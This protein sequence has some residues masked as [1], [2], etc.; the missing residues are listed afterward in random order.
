MRQLTASMQAKLDARAT[1]FCH[2]WRLA[3]RD[4]AIM[5]FTDHDRDLV[6][7]GV[8]FRANT[9]LSASQ[10]E[11]TLGLGVGGAEAAGAL[12]YDGLR[13]SDLLNGLY[14][15]ASVEI[16]LVDWSQVE[17][18][19]LLDVATI[20]EIRRGEHVF[21]A[22]LRSSAH[23]FDQQQGRAFQRGCAADLGDARCGVDLGAAA[24]HTAGAVVSFEGGVLTLDL[25]ASFETGFFAGG[26]LTFTSGA[27]A[28][29][30]LTI[31]T[32]V[33]DGLRATIGLWRAPGA[34]VSAGDAASLTAGCDKSPSTCQRKFDNIVNFRGFPHMPGNDR[35][36]AYPNSLAKAMDGGSFFR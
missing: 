17:D 6:F 33:Q 23:V 21:S 7:N 4:G 31:K 3:R 16:W 28:G 5:G 14:D 35:V 10:I 32:H 2:C 18:R 30:R 20:G 11:S 9:G 29:A 19:A 13:E 26:A 15:G 25:A 8:A 12:S 1:T 36:I 22:E 34:A 24:F 27:N